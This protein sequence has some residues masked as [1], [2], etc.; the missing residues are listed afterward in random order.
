MIVVGDFNI[1]VNDKRMKSFRENDGLKNIIMNLHV[2]KN[3][4]NPTCID[5]ILTN[6][7]RRFKNTWVIETGPSDFHVM[8]LTVVRKG[9]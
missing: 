6:I 1:E 5:L 3:A 9:F 7:L 4:S 2:K 8:T